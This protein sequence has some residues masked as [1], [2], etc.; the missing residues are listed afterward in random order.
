MHPTRRLFVAALPAAALPSAWARAA[1]PGF[2]ADLM[3]AFWQAYDTP[4][5]L[6]PD[7]RAATLHRSFF[8]PHLPLYRRA[9][10]ATLTTKR[11]ANWLPGFDR[12]A[13]ATRATHRQMVRDYPSHL[14][15]FRRALPDFDSAAS[16]VYVLPSLFSFDGHLEPEGRWLPLFFGPD[17][18]V[19]YHGEDADLRVLT[20]HEMFHCYQGQKNPAMCR[21]PNPPMYA[22]LWIEGTATFA[23]ERLNPGASALHVLLDDQALLRDG[24]ATAPRVAARM[25]QLIDSTEEKDAAA[26]FSSGFKGDWPARAG[27]YV[28]LVAARRIGEGLSLQQLAAMPAAE[29]RQRFAQEL[30]RLATAASA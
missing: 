13:A 23:S 10:F 24:A 15:A 6:A 9:G 28:G 5:T 7:E 14:A 20:S 11:V 26:F 18:I 2:T 19:R 4:R 29:V 30:S 25:L 22:S 8:E 16:P 1:A 12:I 27:Y 21:D 3:P 17:A